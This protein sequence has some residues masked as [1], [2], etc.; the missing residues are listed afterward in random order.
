MQV[1]IKIIYQRDK[2]L[3]LS[4]FV[5][6]WPPDVDVFLLCCEC[7][8][9][10][11]SSAILWRVKLEIALLVVMIRLLIVLMEIK[12]FIN[13]LWVSIE[14]KKFKISKKF[15]TCPALTTRRI[16]ITR[17]ML[18][19]NVSSIAMTIPTANHGNMWQGCVHAPRT[20]ERVR[21]RVHFFVTKQKKINN[22]SLQKIYQKNCNIALH[23]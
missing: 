11:N 3:S 16:A 14:K 8:Q 7:Y 5:I 12:L 17:G 22:N 23:S 21:V 15:Y 19:R 10:C 2:R 1:S 13:K 6:I 9:Q 4:S 18:L 20:R